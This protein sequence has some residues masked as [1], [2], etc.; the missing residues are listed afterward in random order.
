MA[1]PNAVFNEIFSTEVIDKLYAKN[2]F[3]STFNNVSMWLNGRTVHIPNFNAS[4]NILVDN[5]D[6]SAATYAFGFTATQTAE[7]D[8]ELTLK[9]FKFTP[10]EVPSFDEMVTNYDKF[11]AVTRNSISQLTERFGSQCLR[12]IASSVT[13]GRTFA[14][15]GG[16][17]AS[18]GPNA[19]TRRIMKYDDLVNIAKQMDIDNIPDSDRYVTLPP[20]MYYDLLSDNNPAVVNA[21]NYGSAV[22]PTGVVKQLAGINLM[23]R[24]TV[25]VSSG[26][27]TTFGLFTVPN[28]STTFSGASYAAVAF[29]APSI[30]YANGD[31]QINTEERN[32]FR[33]SNLVSGELIG[34]CKMARSDGK[35]AYI[36]YQAAV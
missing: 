27:S 5:V 16:L 29:H 3:L 26:S 11:A 31:V 33:F 4:S 35:G 24:S 20:Q 2:A 23:V 1:V 15:T 19:S 25:L 6:D 36:I 30:A 21:Q 18:T 28:Y 14:T 8:L 34:G 7:T 10:M 12:D 32:V 9:S 17:T 13:S 22:L